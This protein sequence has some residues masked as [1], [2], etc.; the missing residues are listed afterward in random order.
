MNPTD[1]FRNIFEKHLPNSAV[2]YCLDLWQKIPFSFK[3][4]RPRTT[5]LGDFRYRKDRKI[6]TITIN[7]DL[8]PYQFLLT[9][10]HEVAHLHAFEKYGIGHVPHGNEWKREFQNLIGPVLNDRVF[11]KDILIPLRHHMQNPS[12]SSARDL[13]LMKEMSKY[14]LITETKEEEIFLS[15]LMPGREFIL[16]GRKFQKGETRR[17]R[18][19]CE[20]VGSGKKYL[21]SRLAKVKPL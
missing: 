16:S 10:I 18:V 8:N 20:E 17:T 13:F 9:Y 19:L 11:P 3:V 4:Q 14:D 2:A 7:S 12:A 6:Q 15:D 1:Q 21:V 5:K